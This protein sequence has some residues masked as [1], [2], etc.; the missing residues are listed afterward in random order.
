MNKLTKKELPPEI[1]NKIISFL[2]IDTRR[3][4]GIYTKLKIPEDI[5]NKLESIPKITDITIDNNPYYYICYIILKNKY[6]IV[7]SE[8]IDGII[9]YVNNDIAFLYLSFNN[10]F[11]Y[12]NTLEFIEI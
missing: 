6:K 10:I 9:N 4:L 5:K 1:I 11:E 7:K 12:S 2:D 3:S 8:I